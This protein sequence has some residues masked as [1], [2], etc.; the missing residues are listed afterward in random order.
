MR[1]A[2]LE[3]AR[4]KALPPQCFQ[5]A[6]FH[7]RLRGGVIYCRFIASSRI[8]FGW[9]LVT[10]TANVLPRRA[11]CKVMKMETRKRVVLEPELER[12]AGA[13][14]WRE[15]LFLAAK[16]E[17]WARQLRVSARI[18]NPPKSS[19]RARLPFVSAARRRLN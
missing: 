14:T 11:G 10:R 5:S 17:R 3:P 16:F 1:T 2:G 6:R 7:W 15:R 18:L 12:M 19:R 8:I 13:F 9:L 4:R